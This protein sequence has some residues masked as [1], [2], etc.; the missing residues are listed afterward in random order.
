MQAC[1]G[2]IAES[3]IEDSR[4]PSAMTDSSII[5]MLEAEV[6][7]LREQLEKAQI[8]IFKSNLHDTVEKQ[9]TEIDEL[10]KKLRNAINDLN[11][12]EQEL[13][14]LRKVKAES[15]LRERRMEELLATLERTE[16]QL[17]QR[18]RQLE[19][20]EGLKMMYLKD[21]DLWE[22]KLKE[23]ECILKE[24][25][26]KFE[27]VN[28]DFMSK[29]LSNTALKEEIK[30]LNDRLRRGIEENDYLYRKL[31]DLEGKG[32][33]NH[34]S[35]FGSLSD[36]TNIDL[37]LDLNN[38]NKEGLMDEYNNLKSRFEKAVCEIRAMKRELRD[39]HI[40][41]DD[42][43]LTNITLKQD[44]KRLEDENQGQNTLMAARIQDLTVKLTA[45]EKQVRNLKSKL[46]DSREKRR[47]LS[48]KGK[49]SFSINKEVEDKITELE[50]KIIALETLEQANG[51]MNKRL[52][53]SASKKTIR[54]DRS[55][56]RSSPAAEDRTHL[57][58]LRRKSLD[59]AT[60]SE[61]M[62][63]LIRL[64][65]LESKVCELKSPTKDESIAT[66]TESLN[67]SNLELR[68][69]SDSELKNN[70]NKVL[71]TA[72]DKV[73]EC[74]EQV[75]SL[76][77]ARRSISPL[78]ERLLPLEKTLVET[79]NILK[80]FSDCDSVSTAEVNVI[81]ESVMSV[82]KSFEHLLKTKLTELANKRNTLRE[83]GNLN[84]QSSMQILAEKLAYET[85]LV[86]RIRDALHSPE[87]DSV[88]SNRIFQREIVETSQLMK[89]LKCKLNGSC[90]K[91]YFS[92]KISEDYLTRVL[93]RKLI[94]VGF[95]TNNNRSVVEQH[96]T[97]KSKD[98][99]K[100]MEYLLAK[101]R[102]INLSLQKYK[103]TRLEQLAYALALETLNYSTDTDCRLEKRSLDELHVKDAWKQA[104]ETVST[105]LIQSEISHVMMRCAQMYENNISTNHTSFFSFFASERAALELWSDTVEEK[106]RAEMD[107][108][109]EELQISYKNCL[110]K[111]R[112]QSS[113]IWRRRVEQE[114]NANKSRQL[115][116]EFAD[117]IAHKALVD[118]RIAVLMGDCKFI[119]SNSTE[120]SDNVFVKNLI[121][122]D[123]YLSIMEDCGVLEKDSLLGGEFQY[124][125][126]HY[127]TECQS[128]VSKIDMPASFD[129]M[130]MKKVTE[131]FSVLEKEIQKL[132]SHVKI[133]GGVSEVI[134][135]KSWNDVCLKC[136]ELQNRLHQ[137]ASAVLNTK[138]CSK[139][140]QLRDSL[141]R[142][143]K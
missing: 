141:N 34:S 61:P 81:S 74:L 133:E 46:Q 60:T 136:T 126:Q 49:E 106:L 83:S 4:V 52:V 15:V 11:N 55:N 115:L 114:R 30:C 31:H 1:C 64:S 63:V 90:I 14:R 45:S 5:E 10:R 117:V 40:K 2:D 100:A 121:E 22:D 140:E 23:K 35:S 73:S 78:A 125:Y 94:Q 127:V 111:L 58:R 142:Y 70:I 139:C 20:I 110:T 129:K 116:S 79:D 57:R 24:T 138:A 123:Q 89:V 42:L 54:R 56:D 104:Q 66:S 82:V 18:T 88:Y 75:G 122:S 21:K 87:T 105:E 96:N 112:Q 113:G 12:S 108:S 27:M 103:S 26:D 53:K 143:V 76:K 135:V 48:L 38:I 98:I 102:D 91:K 43:E 29:Q 101:Q 97:S 7:S 13:V 92:S 84:N 28:K 36:L 119:A 132:Q 16:Q 65:S 67:V 39:S 50:A 37:D 109:V 80:T 44:M 41:Y 86:G 51:S 99:T 47:S 77:Q 9:S 33:K 69:D 93:T 137:V 17:N 95:V 120:K 131:G 19:D 124:L 72:R 32:L 130:Y 3:E 134:E 118:S 8:Q 85:I 68:P 62:K 71:G 25:L 6:Q 59:S 107:K 128:A